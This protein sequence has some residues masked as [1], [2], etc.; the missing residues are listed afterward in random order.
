LNR[1]TNFFLGLIFFLVLLPLIL[2]ISALI[3]LDSRGP[4]FFISK[5]IGQYN[6]N[7]QMIK[8]RTM[9]INTELV[10]SA[11]LKNPNSKVTKLGKILR[12]LSIDEI[13]QFFCVIKGQMAIVGPRPALPSQ[14]SL[15]NNRKKYG[16]DKIMPGIT[17]HAQINGRDLISDKEK[18]N[19]EIEYMKKKSFSLDLMIIL[20]TIKVVFKRM[21]ISH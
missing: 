1:L 21:G 3:K 18:L 17:G 6:Q 12:K 2:V 19:L 14:V 11:K 8:F 9:Y 10:E 16:I 13:P 5:R 7:F 15:I 4:I 20:K